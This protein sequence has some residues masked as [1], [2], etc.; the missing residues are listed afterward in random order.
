MG[1]SSK[2]N[3]EAQRNGGPSSSSE[4]GQAQALCG[5]SGAKP[6]KAQQ[7]A[8]SIEAD[9]PAC[10]YHGR[11]A[12]E[13]DEV[14]TLLLKATKRGDRLGYKGRGLLQ[15]DNTH[16]Q[17]FADSSCQKALALDT[18][19]VAYKFSD[20][21]KGVRVYWKGRSVGSTGLTLTLEAAT[22]P[23]ITVG[24]AATAAARARHMS[25]AVKPSLT[26]DKAAVPL[27]FPPARSVAEDTHLFQGQPLPDENPPTAV[28]TVGYTASLSHPLYDEGGTLSLGGAAATLWAEPACTTALPMPLVLSNADLKSGRKLYLRGDAAGAV[29]ASLTLNG[30]AIDIAEVDTSSLVQQITVED[31][32]RVTPCLRAEH[33]VV[34]RDQG[35]HTAQRKPDSEAGSAA[36]DA[37]QHIRADATR[38]DLWAAKLADAPAYT[39]K[40]KLV[41][42]PTR[43]EVFKDEACTQPFDL[44]TE[45]GFDVLTAAEPF[46]L[47]LRGQQ[48]GLFSAELHLGASGDARVKVDGP[49]KGEMGCAEIKLQVFHHLRADVDQAVE[50][51]VD[52][53]N[54]YWNQLQGLSFTQQAMSTSERIGVGRMLHLQ[55]D[56][57]HARAKLVIE[58]DS[59]HWPAAAQDYTVVLAAADADKA[60]QQRSGA[61][62]VFDAEAAGTEL[63]L[64]WAQSLADA[65][66]RKPLWA[67]GAAVCDAWRGLRLSVGFGRAPVASP[68]V[69]A[70]L[71]GDWGSFTV[72]K[73]KAVRCDFANEPGREKFIDGQKVFVNLDDQGRVLKTVAGQRK[74]DVL[75]EIEPALQDVEV[76][77]SVVEHADTYKITGLPDHFKEKKLAQLKHTLKPVDRS[78]RRKLLTM[79]A[80]TDARGQAKVDTLQAPQ[81][82]L[83]KFKVGAY[84][85]QDPQHARYVD[86]HPELMKQAPALSADWLEVWRRLFFRVVAMKRWSGASYADRFDETGLQAQMAGLGIEFERVGDLVE[87]DFAHSV[88]DYMGWIRGAFGGAVAPART[89]YLCLLNRLD[90]GDKL[91]TLDLPA[92]R[93]KLKHWDLGV[94]VGIRGLA[95]KADW[96]VSCVA[97]VGTT[98]HDVA[99][100]ATLT[101][102]ADFDF[103]LNLDCIALWDELY[104]QALAAATPTSPDEPTAQATARAAASTALDNATFKVKFRTTES[105][106][107]LSHYE[108]VIVCMDTR[109]PDHA[110][111]DAKDS[112][113]HTFLHEIGHYLGLASQYLPDRGDTLNP[114]YY[115]YRSDSSGVVDERSANGRGGYGLGSHCDGLADQCILWY[116][117]R[118][119]LVYCDTCKFSARTRPMHAPKVNGRAVYP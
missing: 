35:L 36:A 69:P 92:K 34:L 77:F 22:D 28:L 31:V 98:E 74:A 82:S 91:Q 42:S 105:S 32:N 45:I 113:T 99:A 80:R 51:D 63:A 66:A 115:Y 2:K 107:G 108:A 38:L 101:Q 58:H 78:D 9:R 41:L 53:V 5:R 109:E 37:A 79:S 89:Q 117:F 27:N 114:S 59:A 83:L 67:E 73:I 19:P 16:C 23:R 88:R 54:T 40:G 97:R 93:G 43:C 86:E 52:D 26:L 29:Q 14:G 84:L 6:P 46:K 1:G 95:T 12:P 50:P 17:F 21:E 71:D 24:S 70:K 76:F 62:K 30:T 10:W 44:A 20:L 55:K 57:H 3:A 56:G 8:A 64:P 72:V 118:M 112:A 33:L 96:L 47:Y 100:G 65:G 11:A 18:A 119:T 4:P 48:A 116:Q 39:G 85:L 103:R 104:A 13:R 102:I 15:A 75:A 106:S 110:T 60:G 81:T 7:V 61:L 111:R 87:K 90:R 49:A 94:Q 68:G 25:N